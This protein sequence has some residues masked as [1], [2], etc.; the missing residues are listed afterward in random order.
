MLGYKISI[1]KYMIIINIIFFIKV[2]MLILSKTYIDY[3]KG[4][5]KDI[6]EDFTITNLKIY[7]IKENEILQ[8]K[9]QF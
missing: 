6:R 2:E 4:I 3:R 9:I 7:E 5:L 8:Q 1:L